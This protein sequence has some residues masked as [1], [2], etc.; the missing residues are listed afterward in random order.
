[1]IHSVEMVCNVGTSEL[2]AVCPKCR[3]AV[4]SREVRSKFG[5][6]EVPKFAVSP[7]EYHVSMQS[8]T[9]SSVELSDQIGDI[10]VE[11]NDSIDENNDRMGDEVDQD[12]N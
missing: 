8:S 10:N 5:S 1:M 3:S 7:L 11:S 2:R 9:D 12:N 4:G 6:V